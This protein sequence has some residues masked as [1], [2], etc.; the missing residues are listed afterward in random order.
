[1]RPV[2]PRQLLVD[3]GIAGAV[4]AFSLALLS[5]GGPGQTDRD[6]DLW[7]GV[8]AALAALPLAV[9]RLTP[10]PV[11]AL[12]S[13]A[14]AALYGLRYG[15]GPPVGFAIASTRPP[16][17]ATKRARAFGRPRS[18]GAWSSCSGRT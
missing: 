15:L 2:R 3:A 17:A 16:T 11:F 18:W 5:R 1:M 4:L 6:L 10:L 12:V 13:A 9:R 14:T 7:S 8:L